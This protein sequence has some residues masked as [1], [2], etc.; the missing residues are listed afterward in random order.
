MAG[1]VTGTIP[2]IVRRYARDLSALAVVAFIFMAPAHAFFDAEAAAPRNIEAGR[3][4]Y[5]EL[6]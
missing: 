1:S 4:T 6:L 5:L 3:E 2:R